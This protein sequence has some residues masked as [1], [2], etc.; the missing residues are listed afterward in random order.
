MFGVCY[1]ASWIYRFIVF[2]IC[3]KFSN[4]FSAPIL[5]SG[6]SV[7]C[8]WGC[9]KLPTIALW[10]SIHFIQPFFFLFLLC[11]QT[12]SFLL[13]CVIC[14]YSHSVCFSSEHYICLLEMFNLGLFIYSLFPGNM[15]KLFFT[16]LNISNVVVITVLM[17][18]SSVIHV[19]FTNHLFPSLW[20]IFP[21][22]LNAW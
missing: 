17:F 12:H 22:P 13:Q 4:I 14:S 19:I 8:M 21:P 9:W 2:I 18:L 6:I 16:F 15:L 20:V 11:I 7:T 5:L 1:W 3:G 10:W